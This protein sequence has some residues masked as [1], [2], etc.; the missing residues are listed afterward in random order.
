MWVRLWER[1]FSDS[2][3]AF[4]IMNLGDKSGGWGGIRTPGGREPTPVFKTGAINHSATHPANLA[5]VPATLGLQGI[6]S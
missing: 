5:S 6:L 2:I 3:Y 4:I 1:T